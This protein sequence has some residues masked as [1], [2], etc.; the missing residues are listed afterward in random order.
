MGRNRKPTELRLIE[1]NRSKRPI[2]RTPKH[3]PLTEHPPDELTPAG[4]RLWRRLLVEF[5]KTRLL[6]RTDRE[7]LLVYCDLW[8]VYEDAMSKVRKFGPLMASR[9][10]NDERAAV[11]KS[12]AWRVA[13][14]AKREMDTL[15]ARFGL[16]PVDRARLEVPNEV[17]ANPLIDILSEAKAEAA[18]R[19][20]QS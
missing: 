9:S 13:I 2:P 20:G 12:P 18:H 4:K 3:A 1:G 7:A 6:Q 14:D 15:W 19:R 10:H 17:A 11:T 8:A 5:G 16:T